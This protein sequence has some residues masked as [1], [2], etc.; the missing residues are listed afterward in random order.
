[1]LYVFENVELVTDEIY[2]LF[3]KQLSKQRREK[4]E[5]YKSKA[6]RILC[7]LA[8]ILLRYA[9]MTEYQMTDKESLVEFEYIKNGKPILKGFENI[10]FNLSHCKYGVACALSEHAVGVDIQD[11]RNFRSSILERIASPYE[12]LKIQ[13]AKQPQREFCKLWSMKECVAKLYGYGLAEDF[14]KITAESTSNLNLMVRESEKY[15]LTCSETMPTAVVDISTL[16][17]F[18]S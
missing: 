10:H 12:K 15:I 18:W 8:F 9:L 13:N 4:N 17:A 6:D 7:V 11:I 3:E 5:Q 2:S 1:M 14:S 16:S